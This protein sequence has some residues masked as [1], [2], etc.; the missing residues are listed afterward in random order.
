M[1]KTKDSNAI[2][3]QYYIHLIHFLNVENDSASVDNEENSKN[4]EKKILSSW[5]KILIR[6]QQTFYKADYHH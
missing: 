4:S 2:L 1:Q 6:R 5:K 3:K